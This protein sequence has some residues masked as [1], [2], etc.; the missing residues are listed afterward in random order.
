MEKKK[1]V[2]SSSGLHYWHTISNLLCMCV[3]CVQ[4]LLS[5]KTNSLA[6]EL[7]TLKSPPPFPSPFAVTSFIVWSFSTSYTTLTILLCANRKV[8]CF[9]YCCCAEFFFVRFSVFLLFSPSIRPFPGI[10]QHSTVMWVYV[11]YACALASFHWMISI[12]TFESRMRTEDNW[13]SR[14]LSHSVSQINQ[15]AMQDKGVKCIRKLTRFGYYFVWMCFFMSLELNGT[16][17]CVAGKQWQPFRRKVLIL[18]FYAVTYEIQNLLAFPSILLIYC[19]DCAKKMWVDFRGNLVTL[20][21]SSSQIHSQLDWKL[22]KCHLFVCLLTYVGCSITTHRLFFHSPVLSVFNLNVFQSDR[23]QW[24]V[25][26]SIEV[27][28][29]PIQFS[30]E[31]TKSPNQFSH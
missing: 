20:T 3:C 5:L 14:N 21:S 25:V 23:N 13:I 26:S 30:I 2:H 29:S 12:F 19:N 22:V 6:C 11:M 24:T 28:G 8:G 18:F 16:R 7:G 27:D 17:H 9:Y 10:V 31:S 1:T 4:L 15:N